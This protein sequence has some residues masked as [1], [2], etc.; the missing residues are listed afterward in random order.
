MR[1]PFYLR[2]LTHDL[3]QW[4]ASELVAAENRDRILAS[5]GAATKRQALP[6]IFGI[7]GVVLL[8][9]AAMSFVAANWSAMDKLARLLVLF[10]SMGAAGALA[11]FL[12]ARGLKLFAD[13]ASL[14]T[15]L[16]FGVAI[17]F[18]GQTYHID[19]G[20]SGGLMLWA[21]GALV[22]ALV[23]PSRAALSVALV[24]G[25][26][27]TITAATEAPKEVHWDFLP[28]LA[29]AVAGRVWRGWQT[30]FHLTMLSFLVWLG[31]NFT[32]IAD[33]LTLGHA[34]MV[35][36]AT[37]LFLALWLL[38][39]VLDAMGVRNMRP[40]AQARSLSRYGLIVAFIFFFMLHLA[41]PDDTMRAEAVLN[42]WLA[43]G[44]AAFAGI[45]VLAVLATTQRA[46]SAL[47]VLGAMAFAVAALA[48]PVCV[49]Y[50][51]EAR[52]D[53]PYTALLGVFMVWGI[54]YAARIED[55][56]LINV[57]FAGFAAWTLYL[58]AGYFSSLF[59]QAA[60][61]AVGGLLLVGVG[62]VLEMVRRRVIK[63]AEAS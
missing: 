53:L 19:T 25:T 36:L 58:Y 52:L 47:D 35:A 9:A 2:Q 57:G 41:G 5:V 46:L 16:M 27:W 23:V 54:A 39:H 50:W 48:Y 40:Y 49:A 14:L 59:H 21:T 62:V 11:A 32:T 10:G 61:F 12:Y 1:P 13:V 17:M 6:I 30:E 24:I 28:F 56:L 51:G 15:V 34:Q 45:V 3:D 31:F 43:P 18:I 37:V 7:L 33:A 63:Q 26:L 44:G 42:T 4:I 20:W 55:R 22:A 29:A 60:F 38:A 8:G